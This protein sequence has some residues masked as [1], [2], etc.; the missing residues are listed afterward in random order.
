MDDLAIAQAILPAGPDLETV[1]LLMLRALLARLKDG[2]ISSSASRGR[3]VANGPCPACGRKIPEAGI[4]GPP[5]STGT[6]ISPGAVI[7]NSPPRV[8][9][10]ASTGRTRP[11]LSLSLSR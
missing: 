10:V 3:A 8:H 2:S 5:L 1:R 7:E 9:S 6:Q 4:E 11:A